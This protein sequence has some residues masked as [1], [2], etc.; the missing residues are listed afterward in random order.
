[1][2][3]SIPHQRSHGNAHLALDGARLATLRQGGSARVML[4]RVHSSAPEVVFLNTSGGLT[5]GDRLSHALDLG[6]G[7]IATATTQTAERA[8]RAEGGA[9]EVRVTLTLG[10]GAALAWL[11]QETI[12]FD[13]AHLQ[14]H[15]RI[16]MTGAARFLGIETIV[17]GRAA[18]GETVTRLTLDDR[19][20]ILRDGRPLLVDPLR[21][22]GGALA[23]DGPALLNGARAIGTL[24]LAGAGVEAAL[25]ALRQDLDE[26][27]VEGAA[28]AAEGRI[29][30]R[31]LAADAWPLRRQMTRLIARLNPGGVPRCWQG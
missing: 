30:L 22:G 31:C 26:P 16:E 29:V 28:S 24:L 9:A 21:L 18:M 4:P 1:M 17:L 10:A 7:T 6:P 23:A 14:R 25:S 15:T 11:P 12:L 19:R 3:D 8:Y 20:T 5:A 13:G 27:G 2:F